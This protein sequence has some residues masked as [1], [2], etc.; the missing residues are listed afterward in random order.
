MEKNAEFL[1]QIGI[2]NVSEIPPGQP[3]ELDPGIHEGGQITARAPNHAAD[4][5]TL[6]GIA[7][8]APHGH[9]DLELSVTG[10]TTKDQSKALEPFFFP[11]RKTVA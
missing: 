8:L 11:N 7:D 9:A 4:P 5:V 6:D 1:P 3:D 2:S 10:Q